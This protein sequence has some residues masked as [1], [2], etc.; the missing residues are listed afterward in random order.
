MRQ[1]GRPLYNLWFELPPEQRGSDTFRGEWGTLMQLMVTRGLY[2]YNGVQYVDNSFTVAKFPGLNADAQ[3]LPV[4]WTFDGAAGA[5]FSDHFPIAAQFVTV[6]EGRRDRYL[7]LRNA[8]EGRSTA[9]P[10]K[11]IDYAKF[12]LAKLAAPTSALPAG[13]PIRTDEFKGK[14]FR[15][16]GRVAGGSRLAV[17]FRGETFDVWSYDAALRAKLRADHPE[18]ATLRCYAELGQYRERWQLVI[19]DPSWVK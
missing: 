1:P 5:G 15:V 16:E 9:E 4:R 10:R 19:Q 12:D 2:D 14:I 13:T 7:A 8:S 11:T 6:T 17:E 3:G 18:G